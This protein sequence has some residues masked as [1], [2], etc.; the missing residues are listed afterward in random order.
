MYVTYVAKAVAGRQ[1]GSF[2][3]LI[4]PEY[5]RQ[6]VSAFVTLSVDRVVGGGKSRQATVGPVRWKSRAKHGTLLSE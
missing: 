4:Q 6:I 5:L 1:V 3:I 2:E